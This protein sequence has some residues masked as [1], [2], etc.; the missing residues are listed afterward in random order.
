MRQLMGLRK[1]ARVVLVSA[2][3]M[4]AANPSWADEVVNQRIQALEEELLDLKESMEVQKEAVRSIETN[5]VGIKDTSLGG[6]GEL[7]WANFDGEKKDEFD[8]QRFIIFLGHKFSDRTRLMSE[9][10]F[11]HAQVKGGESGGEVAMEQA[12]IEHSLNNNLDM[13]AGLQI[14]PIGITNEYHEPPVFYGMERNNIETK[15]IP[16]TWRELGFQL[17]G[18]TIGGLEYFGGISTTPDASKFTNPEKGAFKGMRVSGKQVV[19]NDMGYYAGFNFKGIPGLKYGGTVWTGNTAQD[20]QGKG[21]NEELLKD[22]KATLTIWDLH[23]QYDANDWKLT[24]L[25]AAGT[26]GDTEII[27]ASAGLSAGSD[28]AAPEKFS[29][30]YLEAG[31]KGLNL[32]GYNVQP[33]ARYA[34]YDM[35]KEVAPGFAINTANADTVITYGVSMYLEKDV[36]LKLDHQDFDFNGAN[37]SINIGIG[38]MF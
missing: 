30:Y 3:V 21:A 1:I 26:L 35:Q 11:E 9:I 10:E 16:S 7:N 29:G 2:V 34:D 28:D 18:K 22:V 4:L 25:Y 36:V 37:D 15:I 23:A 13:R 32:G 17:K 27:N 8:T 19:A 6:Y 24:A 12:Y 33:F 38:W 14:I 5:T 20:G 31:Y